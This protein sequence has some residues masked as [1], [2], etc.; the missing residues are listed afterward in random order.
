[1][2]VLRV[3][4]GGIPGPSSDCSLEGRGLSLSSLGH[5]N[6]FSPLPIG[7][8]GGPREDPVGPE[9]RRRGAGLLPG[10]CGLALDPPMG[11]EHA[12]ILQPSLGGSLG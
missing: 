2:F 11:P 9:G 8:P 12:F 5:S 6:A 3:T 7:G 10:P 1:M 4:F